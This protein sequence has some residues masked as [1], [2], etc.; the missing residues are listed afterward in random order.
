MSGA[1]VSFA[2]QVLTI[3]NGPLKIPD[4]S[5]NLCALF[6]SGLWLVSAS[7]R[8]SPLV[9]SVAQSARR[10]GFRVDEPRY[11]TPN[12]VRQAY[13]YADRNQGANQ[14]DENAVRRRAVA[15]IEKAVEVGA[16][17]IHI[18][19]VNN[20]TRVEFRIDG[21]LRVWETWTQREG[22][23]ASLFHLFAFHRSVGIDGQL[24]GTAGGDAH[25]RYEG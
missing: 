2:G 19:A 22:G 21:A 7:H 24:D 20:R 14:F 10:Q 15:T 1:S 5:R 8:H 23:T 4:E 17:D 16:N 3:E 13:L 9:T 11:V 6:D 12:I 25:L 18:E